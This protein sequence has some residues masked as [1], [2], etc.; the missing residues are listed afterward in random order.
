MTR[1]RLAIVFPPDYIF[2]TRKQ[3]IET[4]IH[5]DQDNPRSSHRTERKRNSRFRFV[6]RAVFT[7][8]STLMVSISQHEGRCSSGNSI[9][10]NKGSQPKMQCSGSFRSSLFRAT[11]PA[12]YITHLGRAARSKCCREDYSSQTAESN[13]GNSSFSFGFPVLSAFLGFPVLTEAIF[14]SF[15]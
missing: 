2:H 1:V 10:S 15:S 14:L 9:F 4:Y 8:Y 7:G 3:I 6:N 13:G 12:S 5:H 11:R